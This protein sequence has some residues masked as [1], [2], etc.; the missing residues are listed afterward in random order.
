[1]PMEHLM[2]QMVVL[3]LMTMTMIFGLVLNKSTS[4]GTQRPIF[5]SVSLKTKHLKDNFT[6]LLEQGMLLEEK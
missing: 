1:M 5:P 4:F 6:V 2:L 3:P